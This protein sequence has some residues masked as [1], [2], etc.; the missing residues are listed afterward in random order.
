MTSKK[1][2]GYWS[3]NKDRCRAEAAKYNTRS[4]FNHKSKSAYLACYLNGWLD[5]VCSHMTLREQVPQGYYTHEILSSV[6]KQYETRWDFQKK[7]KGAYLSARSRGVL[8][9]ICSHMRVVGSR[10]KRC[11]YEIADHALRIVYIGLTYN[12]KARRSG[13]ANNKKII[14]AFGNDFEMVQ[15]TDFLDIE[16]AVVAEANFIE[17]YR[18]RGY[19]V[20]NRTRAGALGG[21][22]NKWTKESVHAIAL[23]AKS[24]KEFQ[25]IANGAYQTALKN[26]WIDDVCSH[27]VPKQ[28]PAGY[29]D[30]KETTFAEAQKYNKMRDFEKKSG[31]AYNACRRNG[32]VDEVREAMLKRATC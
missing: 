32:W 8:D 27:M 12:I 3:E 23:N 19:T 30:D 31:S 16:R 22:N 21:N 13:H 7:D 14:K 5:D 17:L 25:S 29:W 10:K 20:L 6:A 9:E 11:V 4:E 1:P 15:V 28:K 26:K 24:R 2:N 18:M